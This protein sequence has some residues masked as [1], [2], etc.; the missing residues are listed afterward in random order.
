STLTTLTF[1]DQSTATAGLDMLLDNVRVTGLP[2]VPN[3]PPVAVADTYTTNQQTALV[4][5]APGLLANDT[6]AESSPLT[7]AVVAQPSNGTVTVSANGS[8]TYTPATGFFGSDSFTYRANDGVANS[9]TATVSITVNQVS[10]GGLANGSFEAGETS[11]I[12]TGNRVVIDSSAPYTAFHG[13]KLMVMNGGNTSPNA[14][15]SQTFTTTPGTE[16]TLS[17]NSGILAASVQQRLQVAVNGASS[18]VSDTIVL[19]GN[20]GNASVWTPRSYVFTA[21]SATTTLTFTDVSTSSN[22][23]DLLLDNVAVTGAGGP[24]NTAPVAVADTYNTPQDTALVVPAAGV[25]SNDTDAESDPL[26]AALNVGPTSGTLTLNPN[27]SFTYT[28]NSGFSGSDSFT[29]HANDGT[30]DSTI[31]TV[32]ITVNA[33]AVGALVNGSFELGTPAS[34]GPVTGWTLNAT[35]PTAGAPFGYVPDG[36]YPVNVPDGTRLLIFN[37]GANVYTGV[38]SQQF[39]T[40]PGQTYALNLNAGVFSNGTAGKKQRLLVGVA[41]TGTLLS[42]FEDIESTAGTASLGLRSYTFTADSAVTTL[43]IADGSTAIAPGS[44]AIGADLLVDHVTVTAV[45]VSTNP[46]VAVSD[47]YT[48]VQDTPL[49]I[50]SPGVLSNDTDADSDPLTAVVV[51]N[52]TNGSVTLNANGGFTYTPNAGYNGSDSFTYRAN[53]GALNSNIGTVSITVTSQALTGLVNGSFEAGL[54]SWIEA[55]GTQYSVNL[56]SGYTAPD[57]TNLVEF[58]AANAVSGGSLSQ[59]F[60]TVPG[61]VYTLTFD[62]GVIAFNTNQQRMQVSVTGTGTLLNQLTTIN[63]INGG[64]VKW[65]GRSYT[66]TADSTLTTLTFTDVSTVTAAID[67]L[68]DNVKAT[69]PGVVVPPPATNLLTNGSFETG[70]FTPWVTAGGTA[71]STNINSVIIPTNGTKLVEFNSANTAVGGSVAQTFTTTPGMSYTLA[72]DLGVLAYNTFQQRMQVDV[73]GTGS[74]LS[75]ATTI[76][77]INNGTVKWE[78][79]S[80]TFTADGPSTTVKFTDTST[81]GNGLDMLLDHV[82]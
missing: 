67:I 53:D 15:I 12:N 24:A 75:Q 55:G 50:A 74:L 47:T 68:L 29:Y 48:T 38:V 25:L 56:T 72:F 8:F 4:I 9:N 60:N 23:G 64:N 82:R 26:T 59:T 35:Y 61:T 2:G 81:T 20:N 1:R 51:A 37:G 78:A 10:I 43:T 66:F 22:G 58:N 7:A 79:R 77:G 69:P 18:L 11:W 31:A 16:Y 34:L 36:S 63:G 6:D 19:T 39:A 32:S 45:N 70:A 17:F 13:T 71:G 27:G 80:Y 46:P 57:G 44:L 5:A 14:V 49:V 41:G 40:T 21:D 65:E 3:T 33:P 54:S 76:N 42:A 73:T 62:L 28:P 52:P 30:L